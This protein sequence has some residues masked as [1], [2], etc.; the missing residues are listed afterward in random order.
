MNIRVLGCHGGELPNFR[1]TSFL[2]N[3]HS[4]LD[5]GAITGVL[6]LKEQLGIEHVIITHAHADHCRDTLF[7]ADN[8]IGAGGKGFRMYGLP[9]VMQDIRKYL[10]NWH[11]WPDF[12]EIPSKERP[13]ITIQEVENEQAVELDGLRV[14]LCT[15]DHTV[16]AAGVI[17]ED[18]SSSVVFSSDTAPT[19]RLWEMASLKS[20]LKAAFI[21]CSYPDEKNDL[22]ALSKHL[23][24]QLVRGE[25]AKIGRDVPVYIYHVKPQF[26]TLITKQLKRG[27][28]IHAE[29]VRLG[30]VIRL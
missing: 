28:G 12:T 20:N 22:A 21:E 6:S 19:E 17:I 7:L 3:R 10:L 29:V 4:L 13:V 1:T 2:I 16:P 5:G 9:V 24:P 15:V 8:I 25:V 23:T 26:H 30:Q 27:K 11:I 18:R 14:T